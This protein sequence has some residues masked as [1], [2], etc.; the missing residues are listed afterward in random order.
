MLL[1]KIKD[2]Y[3]LLFSESETVKKNLCE[4]SRKIYFCF[5]SD[6]SLSPAVV[7]GAA[8]VQY[9]GE[10]WRARKQEKRKATETSEG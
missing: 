2:F 7:D 4:Q 5:D 8:V 6:R 9:T 3:Y 1:F 10:Q